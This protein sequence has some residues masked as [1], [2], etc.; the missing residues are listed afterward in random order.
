MLEDLSTR[1]LNIQEK[2]KHK[3]KLERSIQHIQTELQDETRRLTALE[4]KLFKEKA[5]VDKLEGMSLTALFYNLLGSREEQ[6]EKERQELLSAQLKYQKSKYLVNSLESE[7]DQ[8][9]HQVQELQG[10]EVEFEALL[11]EKEA[12]LRKTNQVLAGELVQIA[13][14]LAN[15]KAE[16]KELDEAIRAGD[17]VEHGLEGVVTSLESAHGWGVWDMLGGGLISTAIKHGKIDEARQAIFEVQ[18]QINHFKRE[19]LDVTQSTNLDVG[20]TPFESF[21][22]Y[23]FDGLIVDWVVQAKID[24]SLEQAKQTKANIGTTLQKL[25][26][27]KYQ[28]QKQ[29]K[30]LQ[31]KRLAILE[32]S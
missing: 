2:R 9:T 17:T 27:L 16:I 13:D 6:I 7:Y 18:A 32:R 23:I 14:Q 5:D 31:E 29:A 15:L 4:A 12:Y 26:N 1:I 3:A 11:A 19:M 30:D 22:D 20:I 24:K 8:I 28:V 10:L 25:R 21:A